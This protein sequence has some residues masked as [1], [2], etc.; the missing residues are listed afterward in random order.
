MLEITGHLV[1]FHREDRFHQV[2]LR[3]FPE[4]ILETEREVNV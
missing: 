3:Q 2:N 1:R 4:R